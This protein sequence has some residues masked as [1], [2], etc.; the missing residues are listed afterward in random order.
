MRRSVV[1][2]ALAAASRL[3]RGL[4][5]LAVLLGLLGGVPWLLVWFIGWPLPDHLPG[6]DEVGTALTSPLDDRAILNLL[7]VL[8]WAL[9]LLFVR[10]V[11]VETLTAAAE[12]ADT[13]RGRSRPPRRR[14]VGPVRLVAA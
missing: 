1:T 9:W 14:P 8:A 12:A 10:D 7:A 6:L 11:L 3:L 13:R 2:R 4:L 5:A